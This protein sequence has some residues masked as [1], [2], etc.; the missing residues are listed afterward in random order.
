MLEQSKVMLYIFRLSNLEKEFPKK[1]ISQVR[2]PASCV[3]DAG[4]ECTAHLDPSP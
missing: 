2:A 4:F 1:G 3:F